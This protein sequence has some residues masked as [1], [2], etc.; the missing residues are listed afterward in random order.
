MKRILLLSLVLV[1]GGVSIAWAGKEA[2]KMVMS[3]DKD[4]CAHMLA[5]FN[6]DMKKDRMLLYEKH[7]EFI[8]WEPV[9]T[10]AVLMIPYCSQTLKQIFDINN[11]GTDELVIRTRSCFQ[12]QLTDRLYIFP[13]DSNAIELLKDPKSQVTS[14]TEDRLNAMTY[15]LTKMPGLK[16]VAQAPGIYTILTLEPFKFKGTFY[17]SMTDLSQE[18]IVIA[19][20]L[21]GEERDDLCYFGKSQI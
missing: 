18:F 8:V 9:D 19:K 13:L 6:A 7:K 3:Q 17:V 4:L 14:T 11:D 16:S 12:S 10:G 5:I 2:Y 21:H 1:L 15:H 20:Y